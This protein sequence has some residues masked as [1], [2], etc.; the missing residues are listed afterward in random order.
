MNKVVLFFLVLYFCFHFGIHAFRE[1][2]GRQ[3]WDLT[4]IVLY[5]IMCSILS[6][7]AMISF[8]YTF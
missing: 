4:K 1:L 3:K 6:I 2:T 8:V 7:I 5:S